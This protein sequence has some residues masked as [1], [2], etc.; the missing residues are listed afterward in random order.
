M[1]SR[2]LM[3]AAMRREPT[4]RIPVMPQ[5]CHDLPVRIYAGEIE[6]DWIDGMKRCIEDPAVIYDLV[7]RLVQQVGCDGLRLFV[8]PEPMRVTRVG[9]ELIGLDRET[10]DRLGR[11]D[12]H[13]GGGL[14]PDRAPAPVETVAEYRS[15]LDEMRR[16]FS[17]E[18]MELLR[19]ARAR[20]PDLFVA[21]SPGGI[22]MNTYTTFRGREQAMIDFFERPDFVHAAMDMQAEASIEQ[23]EKLITT[24][25]DA[26]YIGDPAASASLISPKH[27]ERFCLPA[28]QTFCRRFRGTGILIYI[29]VCGNSRPILE[30]LADTGADV[31]EP[32]DPLGGV[33]VA[34]AKRRIGGRVALM[35]GVN[36]LTLA[37]GTAEEVRAEAIRKC[38]EGGPHGYILAA[39][40]MVPPNTP[41]ESLEAMVEVA[42]ESLWRS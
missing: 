9:D 13:G 27:F 28:Y 22:T 8:K 7:I 5:I 42:K 32:L 12:T 29:H 38:R 11:I 4:E 41:L 24:G 6:R 20:V 19:Q 33:E 40:D 34:D 37:S 14:V 36:T 3:A 2:E 25:I 26:L 31:V 23:A 35:G 30:M 21:S 10:G 16:D 15:R 39:G 1:N 17:D 18:K